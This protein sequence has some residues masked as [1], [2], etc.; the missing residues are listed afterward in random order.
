MMLYTFVS[1]YKRFRGVEL[2]P[3]DGGNVLLQN[4][5]TT[6]HGFMTQKTKSTF[7]QL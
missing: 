2:H 6:L 5:S 7:L 1:G 3:E 4:V